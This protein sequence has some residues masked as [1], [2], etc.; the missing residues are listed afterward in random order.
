MK[1][2]EKELLRALPNDKKVKNEYNRI[3][4]LFHVAPPNQLK[5]AR[6]EI[7]RAAFLGVVLDQLEKDILEIGYE[8]PYKNGAEQYGKKKSAAADLHVSYTKNY[9]AVMKSL[10]NFL[11]S[12]GE[13]DEQDD[14]ERF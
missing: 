1:S 4:E 10:H 5:L 2:Y 3:M 12:I 11:D 7:S 14:F 13:P 8:E 9:L 6:K